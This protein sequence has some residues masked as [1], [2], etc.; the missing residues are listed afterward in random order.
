MPRSSKRPLN[1]LLYN[2]NFVCSSPRSHAYHIPR[3]S[4]L[5]LLY[6]PNSTCKT[7]KLLSYSFAILVFLSFTSKYSPQHPVLER[8]R[9]NCLRV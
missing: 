2:Q 7:A 8:P 5:N 1:P 6:I 4:H 3:K 9:M